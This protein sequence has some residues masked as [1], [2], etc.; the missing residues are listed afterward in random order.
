MFMNA[1]NKQL[2]ID[3]N[4]LD[5]VVFGKGTKPLIFIPGLGDGLRTMKGLAFPIAYMYKEYGKD[6]R[7]YMFSRKNNMAENYTTKDM[8]NDIK[9]SMDLL[10]IEKADFVGVSQ[11]GM[12]AQWCA[13]EYPDIV[14]K[15]V[16]VVTCARSNEKIEFVI[17]RWKKM[18]QEGNHTALMKDNVLYMYSEAYCKK[19][20]WLAPIIGKITKPASY[21]RFLVMADA[22]VS[23][24]C[25]KHLHKIKAKTL[26][27][28]GEKDIT[29]GVEGSKEIAGSIENARLVIYPQWGHALYEEA[30]DFNKVV[31]TFLKED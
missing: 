5:Y 19:S 26:V 10:G 17:D 27:I 7:V 14:D 31:L 28:G 16:L 9:K 13:I 21:D 6:Y 8:A 11:G 23:H 18:A 12:I 25:Y 3:G 24:N 20:L 29:V 30:K 4:T 1:E 2:K 15:L 22:C